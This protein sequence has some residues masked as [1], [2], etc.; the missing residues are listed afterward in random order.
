MDGGKSSEEQAINVRENSGTPRGDAVSAKELIEIGEGKV[1]ALGGLEALRFAWQGAREIDG[2]LCLL[3]GA[4][5][6]AQL[7]V[8]SSDEL[9]ASTAGGGEMCAA[10]G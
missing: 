4:V 3:K 8:R 2:L 1:D 9:A 10:G 7:F 6:K 5:M